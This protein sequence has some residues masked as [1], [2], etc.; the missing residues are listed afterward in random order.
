MPVQLHQVR[1][2]KSSGRATVG[3]EDQLH[4]IIVARD[5]DEGWSQ[6]LAI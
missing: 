1:I 3:A 2:I 4:C 5:V 6:L